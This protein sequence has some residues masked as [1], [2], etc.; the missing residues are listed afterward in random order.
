MKFDKMHKYKKLIVSFIVFVVIAS[1]LGIIYLSNVAY[2]MKIDNEVIGI[3]KN[4]Q[5]AY[6]LIQEIEEHY[7]KVLNAKVK[8]S[9]EITDEKVFVS[10]DQ[11]TPMDLMRSK[12]EQ[13]IKLK[14]EAYSLNVD[15]K[16]IVFV[17]DKK[18]A[19]KILE[20]LKDKFLEEIEDKE[21]AEIS[22]QEKVEIQKESI[23]IGD[24]KDLEEAYEYIIIGSN[25][26]EK[27]IVQEGD[28]TWDITKKNNIT[29]EDIKQAN[30]DI[31]LDKLQ[32]GQ[33]L[34]LVAPKPF[35]NVKIVETVIYEEPIPYTVKYEETD[36]LYL[37]ESKTKIK[38]KEGK[39]KVVAELIKINGTV[40]DKNIIQ[41]ETIREPQTQI[42]LKGTKERPRT[43]AYGNF[44]NPRTGVITS[45]FG[46]RWGEIHT[47][48]DISAPKGSPVLA[49]D[50]GKVIFS[51][52]S[53]SGYGNL[54]I[55]DHENGYVTYYA[56]LNSMNVKK[57]ER[58]YKGQTIATVGA[59]GR[60]TG[61]HLHFEIRK[62]GVPINPESYIKN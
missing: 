62:N 10:K 28:T 54:I 27:Y 24:V 21:K 59:T 3:V 7:E 41:E 51:G 44:T 1:I 40:K 32:I 53:G 47:G 9:Q 23:D 36:K 61:P 29:L 35:I 46:P 8:I 6:Q 5:E 58:V 42:I 34:N 52:A 20:K 17:K 4:K 18:T 16:D 45:R 48:L 37:G 39:K 26:V 33:E 12:L 19:E 15:G 31:D 2:A 57:G 56:H 50:G 22:F 13:N 11:I 60:V 49:A 38:G 55:V 25:K 43:L 14:V 30:P